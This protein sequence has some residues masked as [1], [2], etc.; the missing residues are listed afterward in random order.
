M[1]REAAAVQTPASEPAA[2]QLDVPAVQAA[3]KADGIDAWL[4]YDFRGL[5]PI[6]RRHHRRRPP[7]RA[8]RDEALV[9]LDSGRRRAA[10]PGARDRAR[11]ARAL[12]WR[13]RSLFRQR[14]ARRGPW[15]AARGRAARRDG[16]FTQVRH[17]LHLAR[18]CGDRRARSPVR[19]RGRFV[20]RSRPA[21]RGGLGRRRDRDARAGV[22]KALPRQ[23]SR[24]R[25]HWSA[26]R[27]RH[28]DDRVRH[29]AA[30]G[31]MV[32]RGGTRQRFGSD[33]LGGGKRRQ[34]ALPSDG[35]RA[36]RDRSRGARAARPLGQAGSTRRGVC[37][38]HLDGIHGPSCPRAV[39]RGVRRGV[40]CAR[41]RRSPGAPG[42]GRG[43]RAPRLGGRSR[44]VGCAPSRPATAITSCI[45]RAT[46][47]ANR[48]TATAS[49]WTI[50]RRTTIG[51]FFPERVLRSNPAYTS[52]T[53]ASEAKS[54]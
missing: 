38:H 34:A 15:A 54:T 17:P 30:D 32:S 28:A 9:L 53:S 35:D 31:R 23:G 50:T 44:G 5:N 3:L 20:G 13:G 41:R 43:P 12:A 11:R 26:D 27:F 49:T 39:C 4:L 37:R 21:V 18:R 40:G 51:V 22:G 16:V 52:T 46:A 42:G 14:R 6:A 7:G 45:G 24:L 10:R 25:R 1:S 47:S 2:V 19:R 36:S 33:R 48:F 29:P 8:S